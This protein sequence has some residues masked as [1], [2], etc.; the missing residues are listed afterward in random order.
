MILNDVGEHNVE[1]CIVDV[2]SQCMIDCVW[3]YW[4]FSSYLVIFVL[5]KMIF[6]FV[7]EVKS[8][9][10]TYNSQQLEPVNL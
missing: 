10:Y 7:F 1:K 4:L 3:L 5:V 9:I 8:A 6:S 2:S